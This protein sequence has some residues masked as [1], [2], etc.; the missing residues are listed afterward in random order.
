A[1]SA[2][3]SSKTSV[4]QSTSQ[5]HTYGPGLPPLQPSAL[6][7]PANF[8]LRTPLDFSSVTGSTTSGNGE[9]TRLNAT[10]IKDGINDEFK[11]LLFIIDSNERVNVYTPGASDP[12]TAQITQ[13]TDGSTALTYTQTTSSEAGSFTLLFNGVFVKDHI[14]AIYEQQ[15]S[16]LLISSAAASDV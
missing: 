15:Y 6:R 11:H 13:N 4:A 16:P 1:S 8:L 10:V 5:E 7:G 12:T 9:T 2:R 14:S 3:S